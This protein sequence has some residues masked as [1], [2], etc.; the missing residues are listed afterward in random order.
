M[1]TLDPQVVFFYDQ[2]LTAPGNAFPAIRKTCKIITR[3]YID[4][5]SAQLILY[6][7]ALWIY[8]ARAPLAPVWT[9]SKALYFWGSANSFAWRILSSPSSS[10]RDR[11]QALLELN[12]VPWAE[13]ATVDCVIVSVMV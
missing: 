10:T 8:E 11:I 13:H 12:V 2:G 1:L 7:Y 9:L 4:Y 3:L 5:S 6:M